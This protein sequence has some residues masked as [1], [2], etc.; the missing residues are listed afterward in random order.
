MLPLLEHTSHPA[1][2][3]Y[4]PLTLAR[5]KLL[6]T[7]GSA[8]YISSPYAHG[9]NLTIYTDGEGTCALSAVDITVDWWATLG[10]WGGRYGAPA[11]TWAVGVVALVLYDASQT[12]E[13]LGTVPRVIDSLAK[14]LRARLP[15]LLGASYFISLIPLP[16][17]LWLGN[18]GE[19]LLAP[20]APLMLLVAT[21]LV[22]VSWWLVL[23]LKLPLHYVSRIFPS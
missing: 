20:L 12:A 13:A 16:A 10:R 17:H 2:S 23:L 18:R 5:K 3:H 11:A 9:L 19:P 8:P 14:F 6:H 7:H 15:Y 1:E 4:H 22:S 21:G